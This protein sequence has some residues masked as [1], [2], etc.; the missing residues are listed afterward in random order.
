[1]VFGSPSGCGVCGLKIE[2]KRGIVSHGTVSSPPTG[3][4]YRLGVSRYDRASSMLIALL[5]L[6][7]V[8]VFLL[9]VVFLTSHVFVSQIAVPV[10][11][12][13]IGDSDGPL[14]GDN[15]LEGPMDEEIELPEPSVQDTL[16]A[17]A[18]AVALQAA[19]LDNPA[20]SDH[21]SAGRG[22]DGR[23]LGSGSG[24][25]S[26]VARRWE[27]RFDGGGSLEAYARQLDHFKI[28]LGVLMPNNRVI[29]V[30]RLSGT[31]PQTREGPADQE[32]RY[33]LTWRSGELMAADRELLDRAGVDSQDKIIMKFVP[34]QLEAQLQQMERTRAGAD[35]NR[36]RRTRF[37]ILPEGAGFKFDILDQSYR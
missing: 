22:G 15:K 18:D 33:Y 24:K 30:S 35:A 34:P 8:A 1:M 32:K 36:I 25:G 10:E 5:I 12:M 6:L 21:L 4:R 7:G 16:A 20:L 11:L 23:G 28:E 2:G 14:G 19:I 31:A 26:G 9:L 3:A 29:Y 17:V 13:D 27:V 37:R